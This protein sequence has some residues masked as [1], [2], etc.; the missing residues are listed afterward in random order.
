MVLVAA[1]HFGIVAVGVAD[2]THN[3]K[4][5]MQDISTTDRVMA[6]VSKYWLGLTLGV[7]VLAAEIVRYV[8]ARRAKS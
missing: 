6:I 2:A 8:Q 3:A 7:I 1:A 4:K 5:V